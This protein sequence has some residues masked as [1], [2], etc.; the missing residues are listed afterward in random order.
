VVELRRVGE[1]NVLLQA[2]FAG[3]AAD[4]R[5]LVVPFNG[6]E[7]TIFDNGGFVGFSA[8]SGEGNSAVHALRGVEFE[9]DGGCVDPPA[10]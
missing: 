3:G 7:P 1:L 9:V 10:P 6:G 5:S 4:G 8:G 2:S